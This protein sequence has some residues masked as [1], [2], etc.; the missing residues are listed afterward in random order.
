[1]GHK[2]QRCQVLRESNRALRHLLTSGASTR[3]EFVLPV[4]DPEA[5]TDSMATAYNG[6]EVQQDDASEEGA[7]TTFRQRQSEFT[8]ACC[9]IILRLP[10]YRILC[11]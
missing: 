3:A 5:L 7:R 10:E 1:M 6:V 8:E 2:R 9:V 4:E 11:R